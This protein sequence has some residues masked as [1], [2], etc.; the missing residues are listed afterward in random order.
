MNL[1]EML[2]NRDERLLDYITNLQKEN[3]VLKKSYSDDVR[4]TKAIE[5]LNRHDIDTGDIYYKYNNRFVKSELKERIRETLG[6]DK[7]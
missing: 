1:S 2:F 6:G 5:L 4:I 3:E 7:E